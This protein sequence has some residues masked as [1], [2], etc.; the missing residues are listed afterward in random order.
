MRGEGA[1]HTFVDSFRGLFGIFLNL[2]KT[3]GGLKH[4]EYI[5]TLFTDIFDDASDIFRLRDG[6]V[7]CFAKFLY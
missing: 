2:I 5:K 3:D 1:F 4:E 7:D 6:L